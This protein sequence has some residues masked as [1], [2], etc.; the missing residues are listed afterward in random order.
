VGWRDRIV[1]TSDDVPVPISVWVCDERRQRLA[2]LDD[3]RHLVPPPLPPGWYEPLVGPQDRYRFPMLS[4]VDRYGHTIFSRMQMS[5]LVEELE[6]IQPGLDGT[7]LGTA[8]ALR[9]LIEAHAS[10]PHRYL[11]FVG[12]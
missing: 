8:R 2:S 6:A 3:V 1:A 11:W 10:Q 7:A 5:T 9:V 12:D 4:H